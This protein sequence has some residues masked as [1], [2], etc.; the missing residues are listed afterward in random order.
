MLNNSTALFKD[1]PWRKL[2]EADLGQVTRVPS[3]LAD[4]EPKFYF[5]LGQTFSSLDG[6]FVD[7]GCFVGGSTARFA[8]GI[9]SAGHQS[10]VHAFDRFTVNEKI[11]KAVLYENGIEPFEGRD[12]LPLSKELLAPF[13]DHVVHHQGD[14]TEAKWNGAPIDVLAHD[15]SKSRKSMDAQAEIFWP[16]F[17]TGRTIL[18]QQDYLHTVQPWI[19][20]QMELWSDHFEPLAFIR[21]SS[22]VFLCTRVPSAA[23]LEE[24]RVSDLD[25][26]Q[27]VDLIK[28]ARARMAPFGEIVAKK[29]DIATRLLEEHPGVEQPWKLKRAKSA[30]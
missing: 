25:D 27:Q 26:A 28:K 2:S 30:A 19:P 6:V 8:G 3:M 29:L 4:E 16:Y 11:K 1:R 23:L 17:R 22:M 15:A 14:I 18:V 24:R 20:V 13:A 7:L 9:Q 5:W 12:M 21:G 10:I